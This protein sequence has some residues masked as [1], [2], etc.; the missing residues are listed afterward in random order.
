MKVLS[1][2]NNKGGVCK[3]TLTCNLAAHLAKMNHKIIVIHA[4]P[5]C[6]ATILT[7]GEDRAAPLYW[8]EDQSV[9]RQQTSNLWT[10]LEPIWRGSSS[11]G[12]L[13]EPFC[14]NPSKAR[15]SVGAP[16][17]VCRGC[18]AERLGLSCGG[19]ARGRFPFELLLASL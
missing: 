3:T 14:Q 16:L 1:F 18:W 5:Q 4:D 8:E 11:G 7:L 10:L 6:N 2:F 9:E 15:W 19:A 12:N 13:R 17:G